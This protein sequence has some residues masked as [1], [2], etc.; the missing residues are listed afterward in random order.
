M[1]VSSNTGGTITGATTAGADVVVTL[2]AG[3]VAGLDVCVNARI[4]NTGAVPVQA[5]LDGVAWFYVPASSY[6]ELLKVTT[7]S[8]VKVRDGGGGSATGLHA[9]CWS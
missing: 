3:D 6:V 7:I 5:T 8:Q 4:T 1:V 2:I 9:V